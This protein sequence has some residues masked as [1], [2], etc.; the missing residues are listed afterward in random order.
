MEVERILEGVER[1]MSDREVG[2]RWVK[3]F[4]KGMSPNDLALAVRTDFN[5]WS[6]AVD[7]YR[8]YNPTIASL[9]RLMLKMYWNGP[10]GIEY[11]LTSVRKIYDELAKNPK[12]RE[13]LKKRDTRRYLNRMCAKT[14]DAVYSFTFEGRLT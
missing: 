11:S 1:A 6:V 7:K 2:Y 9:A 8:L 10:G 4:V 14:Y 12:N 3:K 13:V 5:P